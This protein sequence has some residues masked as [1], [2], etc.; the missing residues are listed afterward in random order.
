MPAEFVKRLK[1]S[2]LTIL[3]IGEVADNEFLQ[4]QG[5]TIIGAAGASAP[6]TQ[7]TETSGPDTL[8]ID[9][10]ADGEFLKR[11]GGEIVGAAAGGSPIVPEVDTDPGAPVDGELWLLKT[12]TGGAS[13]GDAMGVLGLTYAGGGGSTTY[14]LSIKTIADGIK[15][16]TVT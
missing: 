3:E 4:R 10:I 6:A 14:E 1:L 5:E 11:V 12:T 15:R 16:I 9:A 8:N 2:D 13:A 7:I